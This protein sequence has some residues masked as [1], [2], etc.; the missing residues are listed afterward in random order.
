MYEDP[1]PK[2][3]GRYVIAAVGLAAVAAAAAGAWFAASPDSA[4]PN[5]VDSAR[6][7]ATT[8]PDSDRLEAAR[9]E[10][11][12]IPGDAAAVTAYLDGPGRVLSRF[13]EELSE[14]ADDSS[15]ACGELNAVLEGFGVSE[16]YG[17]LDAMPDGPLEEGYG[18]LQL[19]AGDAAADCD[20]DPAGGFDAESIAAPLSGIS[21]RYEV[22]GIR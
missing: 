1:K 22:L 16:V 11:A 7:P 9:A 3:R 21:L 6:P 8:E 5:E 2:R 12:A 19:A 20:E 15:S 10:L 18:S 4:D 17:A 14:L 13:E